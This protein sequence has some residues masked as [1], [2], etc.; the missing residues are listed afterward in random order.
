MSTSKKNKLAALARKRKDTHRDGYSNLGDLAR[1]AYDC[2]YVSPYTKTAGNVD[3]DLFVFLQDLSSE[4][5]FTEPPDETTIRLGYTPSVKT[6][7]NLQS[8]LRTH[9][10]KELTDIYATNLFPYIKPGNMSRKIPQ[11]DL[12][13]AANEFALPQLDVVRPHLVVVLGCAAF[14]AICIATGHPVAQS[15]SQAIQEPFDYL[16]GKIWCQA[17]TGWGARHRSG[18]GQIAQD[19]KVMADWYRSTK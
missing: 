17:H 11:K 1:G 6:N 10:G 8:V 4:N 13:W 3:S 5:E 19:W 2:E 18:A 9:F 12:V 7:I 16:E 15:L 14:D